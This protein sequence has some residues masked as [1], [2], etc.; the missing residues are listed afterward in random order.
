MKIQ[1]DVDYVNAWL[2]PS[3]YYPNLDKFKESTLR[4]INNTKEEISLTLSIAN[5]RN[6]R[7]ISLKSRSQASFTIKGHP[8]FDLVNEFQS[9]VLKLLVE[10]AS[11]N[12][13][14]CSVEKPNWKAKKTK[15]EKQDR[16]KLVLKIPKTE[17]SNYLEELIPQDGSSLS[18]KNCLEYASLPFEKLERI[19]EIKTDPFYHFLLSLY[20]VHDDAFSISRVTNPYYFPWMIVNKPLLFHLSLPQKTLVLQVRPIKLREH[21]NKGYGT[22]NIKLGP[23]KKNK[24]ILVFWDFVNRNKRDIRL[25]IMGELDVNIIDFDL[26][27]NKLLPLMYCPKCGD[28]ISVNRQLEIPSNVKQSY[29]NN[30]DFVNI[31]YG[32]NL[33]GTMSIA[34]YSEKLSY[35][36]TPASFFDKT[37]KAPLWWKIPPQ[38]VEEPEIALSFEG[39]RYAME[40]FQKT[41][42][43]K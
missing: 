6:N 22:A 14:I 30:A 18:F 24:N 38:Y 31:V 36:I 42:S 28:I 32:Q 16:D 39:Y 37:L 43:R 12:W 9:D 1:W 25:G 8:I 41:D 2:D 20:A 33:L 5:T 17:K 40:Q 10:I 19:R 21:A 15:K 26:S 29:D 23:K 11:F 34:D 7:I 27:Q 4:I 13:D 3:D 35:Q